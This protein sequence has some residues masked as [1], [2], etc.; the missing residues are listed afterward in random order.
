MEEASNRTTKMTNFAKM[1]FIASKHDIKE[2]DAK[3]AER[4][5]SP[6]KSVSGY[7]QEQKSCELL[8]VMRKCR[9]TAHIYSILILDI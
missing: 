8:V 4:S 1:Q 6:L 3:D 7:K 9:P 2:A 5:S